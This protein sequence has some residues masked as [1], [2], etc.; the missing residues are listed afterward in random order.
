M[1]DQKLD[2]K[3]RPQNFSQILGNSGIIKLLTIRSRQN[4]IGGRSMMFGGS[5]GTGK[6]SLA[7][8]AARAIVCDELAG[9]SSTDRLN[10]DGEPCNECSSCQSIRNETLSGFDEFDAATQ[11]TVDRIRQILEDLEFVGSFGKSNVIIL[12][13]AHRLTLPA[14][15]ALLKAIEDRRLVVILC[16]TEPHKIKPTV[17]TRVEEY[18]VSVPSVEEMKSRLVSICESENIEYE[19]EALEVIVKAHDSGPREC[20]C[21]L[22]T[23]SG[24]GLIS[25]EN[26][27]SYFG[28]GRMELL[29]EVLRFIDSDP[30]QALVHLDKLASEGPTWIRDNIVLAIA[31][32]MRQNVGAR[33]TFPISLSFFGS[34]GLEWASLARIL[35]AIEKPCM[36]DIEAALIST[37]RCAL[38]NAHTTPVLIVQTAQASQ[39]E[40]FQVAQTPIIMN[41]SKPTPSYQA[42][43]KKTD[44]DVKKTESDV[45]PTYKPIEIDGVSFS[46]TEN[47]TSLDHKMEGTTQGH[48]V[49]VRESVRVEFDEHNVPMPHKEF[50]SGLVRRI[51]GK[52][53]PKA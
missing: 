5:K 34:R 6:T 18:S 42:P 26:A 11:G 46:S 44:L 39:T 21:A 32:M 24:L 22:E 28:Y 31:S 41:E 37:S 27:K 38:Q 49:P 17:R 53:A 13:E 4:T 52:A 15:D 36:A 2:L 14:Q 16:T 33:P 25:I 29:A 3:Y 30:K 23:L 7:R 50:S 48:K 47:L 9:L 8:I 10:G 51:K 1:P 12:D 45:K 43:A 19:P 35:G 40:T 20:I